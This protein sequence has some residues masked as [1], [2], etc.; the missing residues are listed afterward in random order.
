MA[1]MDTKLII[2]GILGL[3]VI[4]YAAYGTFTFETPKTAIVVTNTHGSSITC[5][6]DEVI[7]SGR[8]VTFDFTQQP[9]S[10][11]IGF[12]L[13]M[14][15]WC[16]DASS[17]IV[18]SWTVSATEGKTNNIIT[19][20]DCGT[21]IT[22]TTTTLA[23]CSPIDSFKCEDN[24]VYVCTAAG[25][26]KAIDCGS[27]TC[28]CDVF[29]QCSCKYASPTTTIQQ[30]CTDSDGGRIYGL[31]GIT[32]DTSGE[33]IDQCLD[34]RYLREYYCENGIR[35]A[36]THLCNSGKCLKAEGPDFCIEYTCEESDG[37]KNF[38]VDSAIDGY[39]ISGEHTI[40]GDTCL[41]ANKLREYYCDDGIVKSIDYDCPFGCSVEDYGKCAG[42]SE[43]EWTSPESPK[44]WILVAGILVV[45]YIMVRRL[46]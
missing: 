34:D 11:K 1:L 45:G 8:T 26:K 31:G 5:G 40:T 46:T 3:M 44:M 32:T 16:T 42:S 30:Y 37:G 6:I 24:D 27:G 43:E 9:L 2:L 25:W 22:T 15:C 12:E 29:G 38:Y 33:V 39:T 23:A 19:T 14:R 17:T 18:K 20:M 10:S 7:L 4:S 35:K 36:E 41:S 13:L 28:Q 21:V